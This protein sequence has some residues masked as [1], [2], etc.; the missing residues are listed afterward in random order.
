LTNP[1]YVCYVTPLCRGNHISYH[2]YHHLSTPFLYCYD[3]VTQTHL[4]VT[5]MLQSPLITNP[6]QLSIYYHLLPV[7][8]TYVSPFTL[9]SLRLDPHY[10]IYQPL[11]PSNIQNSFSF[12]F[13]KTL[14][15]L[16][17]LRLTLLIHRKM[18]I[19]L[20]IFF[21]KSQIPIGSKAHPYFKRI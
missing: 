15:S 1:T 5:I 18:R 16:A 4:I 21:L 6:F 12:Y 3:S 2:T 17:V 13:I 10:P 20:Q 19:F 7:N 14:E 8:T 11:S 9:L